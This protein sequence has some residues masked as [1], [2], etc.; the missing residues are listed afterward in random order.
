M[1]ERTTEL[2][3]DPRFPSGPWVG[4]FLQRER[5]GRHQM[6]LLLTFQNGSMTGEGRDWV[7]AFVVHGRYCIEDGK[8]WWHKRYLGKHDVFYSGYNEGK[9]IWGK[10]EIAAEQ[11][12]GARL[13]G[14]FHIWP[15]GIGDPTGSHLTEQADVPVDD[16]RPVLV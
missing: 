14:G 1:S 8:C 15:K 5:P 13:H 16:R 7:G 9:G 10:W 2:E 4:F 12:M 11:N 6:E 3:S